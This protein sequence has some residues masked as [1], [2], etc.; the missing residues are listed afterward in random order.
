MGTLFMRAA[1]MA[2]AL[3]SINLIADQD[4]KSNRGFTLLNRICVTVE[5]EKPILQ[6]DI[7]SRQRQE[8]LSFAETQ[9]ALIKER[10]LWVYAKRQ[11]KFNISEI[12]KS[13]DDHIKKVMEKNSFTQENFEKLLMQEPY[14]TTFK[15]YR[16][17]TQTALLKS[18]VQSSI[19][20]QIALTDA[21][22]AEELKRREL[23]E[24]KEFDIVFI[25]VLPNTLKG[26]NNTVN[27]TAQFEMANQIRSQLMSKKNIG[28]VK[29][30]Y[31]NLKNISIIGPMAYEVGTLKK[32]YEEQ[33]EKSRDAKVTEAFQDDNAV[34]VIWKIEKPIRKTNGTALE[35]VRKELYERVVMDK[36]KAVIGAM[37]D[38]SSVNVKRCSKQ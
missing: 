31:G 24:S 36:Y 30:R 26:K 33:L 38:V 23:Q 4:D 37:M 34:T 21:Q 10:L 7:E 20:N 9:D 16:Y 18:S 28:E 13:A 6:S 19:A 17:D 3:L 32:E 2:I 15:Q 12:I 22:I 8:N 5:G 27:T 35:K 25:S 14:L 11:L 29:K 1:T